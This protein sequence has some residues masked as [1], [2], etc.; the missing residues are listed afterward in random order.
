MN[1]GQNIIQRRSDESNLT[2]PFERTFRPVGAANQPTD[3]TA[4][5]Q[6]QFCGCGWPDHMLVPKGTPEGMRFDLFVMISNFA[7]DT[8]NQAIDT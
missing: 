8:V 7:D 5:S 4:L 2:I 6:F 1:P 3:P